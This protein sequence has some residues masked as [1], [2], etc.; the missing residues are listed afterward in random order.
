MKILKTLL[1]YWFAVVSVFSFLLG[2]GMLAHS[3]KPG[4]STQTTTTTTTTGNI[5]LPNLPAI[6]AF[7]GNSSGLNFSASTS[8]GSSSTSQ[9]TTTRP[10][11]RSGGS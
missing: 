10:R 2:W 9:V 6:Q 8:S 3:L 4:Q 5:V 1:H 7:G 11:L